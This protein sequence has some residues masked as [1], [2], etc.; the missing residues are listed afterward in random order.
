MRQYF[1]F[2]FSFQ[3]SS[4]QPELHIS[5]LTG[6]TCRTTVEDLHQLP[7][8]EQKSTLSQSQMYHNDCTRWENSTK[9]NNVD[10]DQVAL[11]KPSDQGLHCLHEMTYKTMSGHVW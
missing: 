5:L 1:S 8:D 3:G 2:L 6:Y 11:K 9:Q 4:F 7:T 10:P